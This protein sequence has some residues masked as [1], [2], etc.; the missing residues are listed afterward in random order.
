MHTVFQNDV[1]KSHAFLIGA[2]LRAS[3][4]HEAEFALRYILSLQIGGLY[5]NADNEVAAGRL[6][7]H[8]QSH[9]RLNTPPN[10]S[11]VLEDLV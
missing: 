2:P 8:L 6:P 7:I 11:T 10:S 5:H 9:S 1:P 3:Q 4:V